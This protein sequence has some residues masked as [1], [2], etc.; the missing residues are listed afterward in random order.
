MVLLEIQLLVPELKRTRW[1]KR[2]DFYSLFSALA[3][4]DNS[5]PFSPDHRR[6]V[7]SRLSAFA[8]EVDEAVRVADDLTLEGAA[9]V[10]G[11]IGTGR[12]DETSSGPAARYADAVERAATDLARR[13]VREAILVDLI[14]E[15]M[16]S[17]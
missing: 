9:D 12:P 16:S 7:S 6:D 1:R 14:G 8:D 17:E 13:R 5:L 2:S 10:V 4:F 11:G 3:R 15:G